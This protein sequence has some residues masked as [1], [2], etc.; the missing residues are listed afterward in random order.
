MRNNELFLR[1]FSTIILIPCSFFVIYKGSL[2]FNIFL[3]LILIFSIKEWIKLSNNNLVLFIG[4][5]FLLLSF[6]SA[7]SIRENYQENG[8]EIFLFLI[9]LCVATDMGGY[10]FGKLLKGPKL[11]KISPNKTYAGV[12]GGF[13]L[14]VIFSYIYIKQNYLLFKIDNFD[15]LSFTFLV[16]ILSFVSQIGDLFISFFKR[17]SNLDN[18]GNLIPGHGGV[19]DRIDGVIFVFPFFY[20]TNF[21]LDLI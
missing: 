13:L 19:L 14:S 3:I 17:K 16:L 7:Y 5:I 4:I 10:I 15:H 18:T 8:L 9:I 12:F 20:I 6:Y 21:I 11:T 2:Y 1:I